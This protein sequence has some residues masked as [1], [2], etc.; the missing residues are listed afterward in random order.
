M[1]TKLSRSDF[2][3]SSGKYSCLA[4]LPL[5]NQNLI[6][7]IVWESH[8][9]RHREEDRG[10]DLCLH[11]T[12]G[13][14]EYCVPA[15]HWTVRGHRLQFL[16]STESRPGWNRRK[17][18]IVQ[19]DPIGC[20]LGLKRHHYFQRAHTCLGVGFSRGKLTKHFSDNHI[21]PYPT[22]S[23]AKPCK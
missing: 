1:P 17:W 13:S 3:Q 2:P 23:L 19:E 6:L 4:D 10:F 14:P 18:E 9:N 21:I 7:P 12:D 5:W 22:C 11:W 20:S 8:V 16:F 15:S